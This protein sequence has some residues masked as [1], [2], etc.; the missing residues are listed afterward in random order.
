MVTVAVAAD[1]VVL[2]YIVAPFDVVIFEIVV[3]IMVL[4]ITVIAVTFVI[5]AVLLFTSDYI[6]FM[7]SFLVLTLVVITVIVSPSSSPAS[8]SLGS[9]LVT[10]ISFEVVESWVHIQGGT[11]SEKGPKLAVLYFGEREAKE[12]AFLQSPSVKSSLETLYRPNKI[13]RLLPKGA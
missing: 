10:L 5:V 6:I 4:V 1:I 11:S 12:G 13:G 7:L 3:I 9:S 8:P 2:F